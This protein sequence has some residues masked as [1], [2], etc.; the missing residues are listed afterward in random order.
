MARFFATLFF[1]SALVVSAIGCAD[2]CGRAGDCEANEVCFKGICTPNTSSSLACRNA[3]DCNPEPGVTTLQCVNARCRV[4]DNLGGGGNTD[5]GPSDT[6]VDS[7][8]DSGTIFPDATVFPD[9][10]FPDATFPD[11]AVTDTG[12]VADAG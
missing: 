4:P 8:T 5:A 7:G 12:I 1:S 10:T 3:A 6:G 2:E 11:A 9:A